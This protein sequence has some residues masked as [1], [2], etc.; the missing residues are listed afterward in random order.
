MIFL[1]PRSLL[2][3][4][5]HTIEVFHIGPLCNNLRDLFSTRDDAIEKQMPIV[6]SLGLDCVIW[7]G[8][9]KGSVF[10]DLDA[11]YRVLQSIG[12][13]VETNWY[14]KWKQRVV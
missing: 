6:Q 7:L 13:M 10:Q 3:L 1:N 9:A 11:Y 12:L 8:R 14:I 5:V 4:Y 2:D